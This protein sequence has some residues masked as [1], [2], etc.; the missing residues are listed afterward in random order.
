MFHKR[1]ISFFPSR[2]LLEIVD[3]FDW[4]FLY[5]HIYPVAVLL[6]ADKVS[7]VRSSANVLVSSVRVWVGWGLISR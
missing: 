5:D 2:Q 1:S 6:S 4:V 3:L 7:E